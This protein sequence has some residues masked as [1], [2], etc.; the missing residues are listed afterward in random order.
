MSDAPEAFSAGLVRAIVGVRMRER[1][2]GTAKRGQA[3][4]DADR[5]GA[6]G[7]LEASDR[8]PARLPPSCAARWNT[9]GGREP[10]ADPSAYDRLHP[11]AAVAASRPRPIHDP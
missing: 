10:R 6:I 7:G 9:T 2:T 3:R 11:H 4:P 5:W 1:L 8:G